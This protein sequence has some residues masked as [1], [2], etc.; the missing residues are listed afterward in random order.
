MYLVKYFTVYPLTM[1]KY[2][3]LITFYAAMTEQTM[4]QISQDSSRLIK[5]DELFALAEQHSKQLAL[6]REDIAISEQKTDIAKSAHLP[7][8]GASANMGYISN[9]FVWD[10][11]L[12][13]RETVSM[14]HISQSFILEASQIIY[15]GNKINNMVKK[16]KLAEQLAGLNY[17]QNREDI[18]FLLLG[19]Y[20]D[21]YR[22]LNEQRVYQQHIALT[23]QRLENIQKLKKEGM[24]TQNDIIRTELLLTNFELALDGVSDNITIANREL[25]VVL[26][27]STDTKIQVD[28]TLSAISQQDEG[29]AQH[30]N[31][32]LS[33]N[34]SIRASEIKEEMA[35]KDIKV[36]KG[37]KLPVI[38]LYAE[39]ASSRPFLYAIPPVDIYMNYFQGGLRLHYNIS[40]LYHAKERINLAKMDYTKQQKQTE[41]LQE[42]TELQVH[43]AYI[44][45]QESKRN[46]A[47][48]EKGY[49]LANSNYEIVE[50]KY[51]NQFAVLTDMLDAS[52]ARLN[53]ELQMSN[54]QA[55]ILFHWYQ[56]QKAIGKL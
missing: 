10:N 18:R 39:D 38:S 56:L 51:Y 34:P 17:E 37:D 53:A 33:R 14:P 6:S 40:S 19:R 45:W 12:K 2:L 15:Q 48:L 7:E 22:L 47:S 26:G 52:T 49:Q 5:I 36:A 20:F 24:V 25:C 50:N 27:L 55:T 11:H 30:L 43:E 1:L 28:T 44:K 21:I 16:A 9:A 41:L 23:K 8:F 54:A 3:F 46:Y 32:A 31:D 4:A 13:N 35:Q 29:F 42:K